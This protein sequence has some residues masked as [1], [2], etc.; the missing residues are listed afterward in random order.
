M[1]RARVAMAGGEAGEAAA[2]VQGVMG[3]ILVTTPS[4]V[5]ELVRCFQVGGAHGAAEGW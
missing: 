1:A 2:I 5:E 3:R 4:S